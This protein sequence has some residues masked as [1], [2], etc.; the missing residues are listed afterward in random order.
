MF[1]KQSGGQ[2]QVLLQQIDDDLTMCHLAK[3]SVCAGDS[4]EQHLPICQLNIAKD[5]SYFTDH[6]IEELYLSNYET[7]QIPQIDGN[8]SILEE[9]VNTDGKQASNSIKVATHFTQ[10]C[11]LQPSLSME[12]VW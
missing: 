8:D 6:E 1:P 11:S 4:K 7:F 9:S 3:P 5:E 10:H 12:K 2:G